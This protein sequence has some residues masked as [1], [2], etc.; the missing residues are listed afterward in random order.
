MNPPI[1]LTYDDG[2]MVLRALHGYQGDHDYNPPV[3]E[4]LAACKALRDVFGFPVDDDSFG[5]W[6]S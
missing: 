5:E 3:E 4:V 1:P 2:R 6:A